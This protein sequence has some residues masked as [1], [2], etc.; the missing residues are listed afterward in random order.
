MTIS[1]EILEEVEDGVRRIKEFL[2]T[3]GRRIRSRITKTRK[4]R[5]SIDQL[6]TFGV[7][8]P[9]DFRALYFNY[10]GAK[11][12][13]G[14]RDVERPVFF[15]FEWFE[16]RML[17]S[18][19]RILRL[20]NT[21]QRPDTLFISNGALAEKLLLAPHLSRDGDTPLIV[22]L[23]PLST[24]SFIAFDSTLA[25]LR[26]VCAAQ[27]AGVLHFEDKELR[28]D[29]AEVWDVIRPFNQR[30]EY[31]PTLAKGPIEWDCIELDEEELSGIVKLHP[32]TRRIINESFK[33]AV[34]RRH[35]RPKQQVARHE[36]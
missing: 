24:K 34:P 32:E 7:P 36:D 21:I 20:E 33:N 10:N 19:N 25:M 12:S 16:V 35:R 23:F 31:W 30:S 28:F 4:G 9:E 6:K 15:N 5:S 11:M 22:S 27:D 26:S 3:N 17:C 13:D 18:L 1:P 2:K 29:A 14:L 8:I